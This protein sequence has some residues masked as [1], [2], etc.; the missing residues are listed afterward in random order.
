MDTSHFLKPPSA[1]SDLSSTEWIF[2]Q[3][4][5]ESDNLQPP[6]RTRYHFTTITLRFFTTTCYE[7]VTLI[8]Q[9]PRPF[10]TFTNPPPSPTLAT[11]PQ[12]TYFTLGSPIDATPITPTPIPSTIS[13]RSILLSP[14]PPIPPPPSPILAPKPQPTFPN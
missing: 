4:K 13:F 6:H 2:N 1:T 5:F 11:E 8:S 9:P 12:P 7:F 14:D 10:P 3:A